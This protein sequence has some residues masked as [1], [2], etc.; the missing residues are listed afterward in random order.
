MSD[1]TLLI[2]LS[3]VIA[4]F[5]QP[6]EGVL[7]QGVPAV[8][9]ERV[10]IVGKIAHAEFGSGGPVVKKAPYQAEAVT[11]SIQALVD[12]NRIIRRNSMTVARDSEGRTRRDIAVSGVPARITVIHDPV[13]NVSYTLD[14]ETKT[15]RKMAG[16][17]VMIQFES[18]GPAGNTQTQQMAADVI[19]FSP[20]GQAPALRAPGEFL[21]EGGPTAFNVRVRSRENARTEPLG[22]QTIDGVAA[23]GTRVTNVIPAGEIGNELPLEITFERWY[24]PELQILVSSR[25]KDPMMGET[26]YKLVNLIRNEPLKSLFEIPADYTVEDT[27][28]PAD[29]MIH[30]KPE[31]E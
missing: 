15:G 27:G 3:G 20:A 4:V 16:R 22:K 17:G 9:A 24:S 10:G 12:G 19:T 7:M 31:K 25:H 21:F 26:T 6:H 14:H 29:R 5:G 28:E 13:A 11:E 30:R 23:E 18:R 1:K 2:A 8:R